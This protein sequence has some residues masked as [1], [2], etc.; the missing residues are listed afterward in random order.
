[1]HVIIVRLRLVEVDDMA[2]IR[3]VQATG[4]NVGRDEYFDA[5]R[6]ELF[7]CPFALRLRFV[8]VD[9]GRA[10]TVLRQ[11]IRKPLDAEF[12]FAENDNLFEFT[13]RQHVV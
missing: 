1:M 6:L 11:Q 3:D 8:T 4:G 12:G 2:D 9:G 7:E 10:K 13:G 5:L